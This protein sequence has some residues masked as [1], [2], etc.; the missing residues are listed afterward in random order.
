M[1]LPCPQLHTYHSNNTAMNN[2][3][4]SGARARRA[5]ILMIFMLLFAGT[6]SAQTFQR[7][8]GGT[9]NEYS[10]YHPV[11]VTADGG[12]IFVG[13]TTS[14]GGGGRDLYLT[15]FA[16]DGT[17]QWSGAYGTELDEEGFDVLELRDVI[18]NTLGYVAVGQVT[19]AG[20]DVDV[21]M[22]GVGTT[23]TQ[24]WAYTYGLTTEN[25]VGYAIVK[26][27]SGL[28]VAGRRS[29]PGVANS[30]DV[31]TL[32]TTDLGLAPIMRRFGQSNLDDAGF[33]AT[34]N[35]SGNMVIA[36]FTMRSNRTDGLVLVCDPVTATVIATTGSFGAT[37]N[38]DTLY[39]V[40]YSGASYYATGTMG[41]SAT[42][43]DIWAVK[44]DA[45]TG[46]QQWSVT[47]DVSNGASFHA[48][49]V[50]ADGVPVGS[51]FSIVGTTAAASGSAN[52][53]YAVLFQISTVD[54]SP[55]A[56]A[57]KIYGTATASG[58]Y[59]TAY[60]VRESGAGRHV[61]GAQQNH[62]TVT[63][64]I[65]GTYDM[66][67]IRTNGSLA[68]GCTESNVTINHEANGLRT[69]ITP[70]P[71][72][73]PSV[74]PTSHGTKTSSSKLTRDLCWCVACK[75]AFENEETRA[76]MMLEVAEIGG[77]YVARLEGIEALEVFDMAGR[78]VRR[79]E[80]SGGAT[81]AW[82]G[83]AG[84]TRVAR[85]TYVLSAVG[86]NGRASAMVQVME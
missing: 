18:G 41:F 52:T 35:A 67:I 10:R 84:G 82:D 19:R 38:N 5:T 79:I 26:G 32:T 59:T 85:G 3:T 83:T 36:G 65:A 39:S 56:N 30:S 71:L 69:A 61:I 45:A 60:G 7:A 14:Y 49:N 23:G 22:V 63:G 11:E 86:S 24:N 54:G 37:S 15:K 81:I 55:I 66:H 80:S 44:V 53:R 4:L 70:Q 40:V 78:M 58:R 46:N 47:Y 16:A 57:A 2:N 77:S 68:S 12:T 17:L 74:T 31:L 73:S 28:A 25:E 48:M 34:T 72:G 9:N 21:Y 27:G 13:T 64:S 6:A 43:M 20:G 29:V 75:R 62:T 1:R 76:A 50:G 33:G 8:F 42:L 51:A